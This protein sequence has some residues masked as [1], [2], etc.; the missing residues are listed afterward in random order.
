[1]SFNPLRVPERLFSLA[2]WVVSLVFASFLIGLGGKLV[3]ELPGVEQRVDIDQFVDSAQRGALAA[4]FDSLRRVVR[5]GEGARE[6]A[7]LAVTASDNAYAAAK[8]TFDNWIATRSATTDPAQDPEVIE[9]T[10]A[11]D[12]LRD[13]S[14]TREEALELVDVTLL[15]ARQGLSEVESAQ[16]GLREAA[17]TRFERAQFSQ[18]LGVFGLR[19]ALTLPLLLLAGWMVARKRRTDYWPLYRGFVLFALFAFFVELV[20]YLPSYGGYVR[21][22]VGIVTSLVVGHFVIRAMRQY[23][24]K[25]QQVAQQTESERRGALRYEEALK[26]MSGGVCPGCE[27]AIAGGPNGPSNFCVHCGMMLF[28]LCGACDTR[29]NAFFQYCPSCG[30]GAASQLAG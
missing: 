11:L 4:R 13:A 5:E 28:D 22:G 2:M 8:A 17:R 14:R 1:M 3:G 23:L 18:E 25:R 7:A 9:R 19:L 12:A 27:R 26:K 15:R 24:A 6:R 30:T 10:R 29:K 21:Y 16:E 20:P